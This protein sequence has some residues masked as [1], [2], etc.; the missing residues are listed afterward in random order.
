MGNAFGIS[1]SYYHFSTKTMRSSSK[2]KYFFEK[3]SPTAEAVGGCHEARSIL[4]RRLSALPLSRG[5]V[6]NPPALKFIKSVLAYNFDRFLSFC[7]VG[8]FFH[9]SRMI[10]VGVPYKLA[11]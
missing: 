5:K 1:F 7:P 8:R 10:V 6:R 11:A 4:A 3:K 9:P 2:K